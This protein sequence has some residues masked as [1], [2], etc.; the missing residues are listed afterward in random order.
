MGAGAGGKE[1]DAM[2]DPVRPPHYTDLKP[3]PIE[4]IEGWGLG[5]CL[6]NCLKYIARAGRKSAETELEDLKKARWYLDRAILGLQSETM[7]PISIPSVSPAQI[8]ALIA[9]LLANK[10]TVAE[11]ADVPGGFRIEGHGIG[12]NAVYANQTLTVTVLHKPFYVS[13]SEIAAGIRAALGL[14]P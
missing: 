7:Q 14:K 3:E 11:S 12:A 2:S 4:A 10:S 13:T 6:G 5:F 9:E 1:E 8:A